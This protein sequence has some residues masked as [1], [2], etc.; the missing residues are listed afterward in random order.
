M[1]MILLLLLLLL[2]YLQ[3]LHDLA[4]DYVLAICQKV[5]KKG[6]SGGGCNRARRWLW[7]GPH[8]KRFCS[9]IRVYG[10]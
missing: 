1:F 10:V 8:S 6:S 5:P 3:L 9:S 7:H 4:C 2:T